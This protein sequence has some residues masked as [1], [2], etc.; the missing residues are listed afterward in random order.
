M[1]HQQLQMIG[2][3]FV[4]ILGSLVAQKVASAVEQGGR[5]RKL[6]VLFE[7]NLTNKKIKFC[8]SIQPEKVESSDDA[9]TFAESILGDD[10]CGYVLFKGR[11]TPICSQEWRKLEP[12]QTLQV[13]SSQECLESERQ[14]LVYCAFT[15]IP[16]NRK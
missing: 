4:G 14:C 5:K 6:S 8:R 3:V 15:I 1:N 9:I 2:G 10:K 11:A 12:P 16:S 7:K 13:R